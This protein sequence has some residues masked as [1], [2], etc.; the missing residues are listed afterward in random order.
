M[1]LK[2]ETAYTTHTSHVSA[3]ICSCEEEEEE[4]EEDEE[5]ACRG[6]SR[7]I[8]LLNSTDILYI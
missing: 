7:Q 6:Y 3:N 2:V 8:N 1:S 4:E 5:E